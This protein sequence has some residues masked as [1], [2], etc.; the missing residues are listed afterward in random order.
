MTEMAPIQWALDPGEHVCWQ[1][2][3]PE[4][5]ADGR[6]ALVAHAARR[7]GLLLVIGGAAEGERRSR[8]VSVL[9]SGSVSVLAPA[10]TGGLGRSETRS[11]AVLRAVRKEVD[12]ARR[13]GRVLQVL[14]GMEHLASPEA[15]LDEL[16]RH[17]L[18][19]AELAASSGTSVVC[20]Y[21]RQ[22]WKPGIVQDLAAVHS[23]VVGIQPRMAGFRLT[24]AEAGTWSL[25]GSVGFESLRAFSAA[26]RGALVRAPRMRLQCAKLE[27][28]DAS[29]LRT[30]IETVASTPGSSVVLDHAN[31]TV[32]AA[33]RMSGY[34]ASG[35]AVEVRR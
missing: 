25:E 12:A 16:V 15:P 32:L 27:L 21:S 1:V 20:A 13:N 8:S 4:E 9:D 34:A 10:F 23:R 19:L 2:S 28:I 18:D 29:G 6:R 35:A 22:V 26:L 11:R 31:E 17:E 14:A 3:S 24:C 7:D 33:W 5:Y 30:L